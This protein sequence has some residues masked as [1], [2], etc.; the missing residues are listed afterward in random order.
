M[1]RL[2]RSLGKLGDVSGINAST[3]ALRSMGVR[4]FDAFRSLSR[5]I[6]PLAAI[7]SASSVAGLVKATTAFGDFALALSNQAYRAKTSAVELDKFQSMARLAG[8]PVDAMTSGLTHL[9][10]TMSAV[11][12]KT[13]THA[14]AMLDFLHL[15]LKNADGSIKTT[16][17]FLPELAEATKG[18]QDPFYKVAIL[19]KFL[20]GSVEELLPMLKDGQSGFDRLMASVIK[21]GSVTPEG[22]AN[23]IKLA[24]AQNK[25]ATA[26]DEL[27]K[28]VSSGL[29][30]VLTPLLTDLSLWIAAHKD[31]LAT[32]ISGVVKRIGDA[33]ENIDWNK[34]STSLDNFG[35]R[36]ETI[37]ENFDH[38][39]HAAEELAE[40][41]G[42]AWII[43][44][45]KP[46]TRLATVLRA[47]GLISAEAAGIVGIGADVMLASG[48]A[49]GALKAPMVDDTG[50]VIGNWS[51]RDESMN[52]AA[53]PGTGG[54]GSQL[55][56]YQEMDRPRGYTLDRMRPA[57]PGWW[58]RNFGWLSHGGPGGPA[59]NATD[60][61]I[62]PEMRGLLDTIARHEQS[63]EGY[64][65]ANPTSS[66][67]GRYQF[68]PGS[69]NDAASALGLK[70]FS[71]ENQDKA[72][73]WL[74][75]RA[76]R[77]AGHRS[78]LS[79]DLKSNDPTL[80]GQV[81]A[82]LRGVW[83]SLPGG[84]QQLQGM[85]EFQANIESDTNRERALEAQAPAANIQ[86]G[87]AAQGAATQ[88]GSVDVRVQ[89]ANT[90]KGTQTSAVSN[91][92]MMNPAPH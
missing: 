82:A 5:M 92:A 28:A 86:A 76:W 30:P 36:V 40:F 12:G 9:G 24:E 73:K 20:G 18:V 67:R 1:E 53:A 55:R 51:G 87:D 75:E 79:T 83:P 49:A 45:L 44:M 78:D 65:S 37:I 34:V 38:W 71:P 22:I 70:D 31:I 52:P 80:R 47:L 57:A 50:H 2:Q 54:P 16:T 69:W 4:A 39:K 32:D 6:E 14:M 91:G 13:D 60:R 15:S 74:A 23:G 58:Q 10:D 63:K 77:Q 72:A 19:T 81:A 46:F 85:G 48:A 66:A 64:A 61:S 43:K 90:P 84:S 25:V 88:R 41:L 62:A 11:L 26:V 17:Q 35:T 3:N 68:M 56:E 33:I 27:W 7:G 8:V 89:F 21:Y 59:T 42:G 29:A